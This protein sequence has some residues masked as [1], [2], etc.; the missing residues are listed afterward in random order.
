MS[1]DRTAT[2]FY[3][4]SSDDPY[5]GGA[6]AIVRKA[7]GVLDDAAPAF[8]PAASAYLG[9]PTAQFADVQ[10]TLSTDF[11]RVGVITVLGILVVLVILLRAIVA[12]LYLVATVLDLVR[13]RGRPL[14]V[15]LPGGP[16]ASPAC[17]STCR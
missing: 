3:V 12:P 15:D 4:T 7:Q 16:R 17:R 11:Q 8:G 13:L 6:F 1:K 10:D 9:G 5:S 2:R 14:R